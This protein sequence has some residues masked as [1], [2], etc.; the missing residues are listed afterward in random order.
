VNSAGAANDP[1]SDRPALVRKS[2][3]LIIR[4]R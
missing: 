1:G 3:R 4:R 2:L